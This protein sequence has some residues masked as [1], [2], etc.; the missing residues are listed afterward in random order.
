MGELIEGV[1]IMAKKRKITVPKGLLSDCSVIVKG[2][3]LVKEMPS[4]S[5]FDLTVDMLIKIGFA[6]CPCSNKEYVVKHSSEISRMAGEIRVR[7]SQDF[8][9]KKHDDS[10]KKRISKTIKMD[11]KNKGGVYSK[12]K[13][14]QYPFEQ[15][16]SGFLGVDPTTSAFLLSYEWRALRMMA[17]K[18]YGRV[19]A[20]CGASGAGVVINVDHIKPRK[21]YP[22]LALDINNTQILCNTC[23][24]GKGNW[25]ETDWRQK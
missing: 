18:K 9:A 3:L 1:Y 7:D 24:H 21:K 6:P 12:L 8:A 16:E 10:F 19:C 2:S 25:D 13:E 23:N 15:K 4:G 14:S 5:I 22:H 17:I 20:C 11:A